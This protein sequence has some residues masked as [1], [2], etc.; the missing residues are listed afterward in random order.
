MYNLLLQSIEKKVPITQAAKIEVQ[1]AFTLKK[2]RKRDYLL[3]DGDICNEMYFVKNGCMILYTLDDGGNEHVTQF[4]VEGWWVGDMYSYLSGLPSNMFLEALEPAEVLCIKRED[5]EML[6]TTVPILERY[7]RILLE[8]NFVAIHRRV[9]NL[10]SKGAE[11]KYLD[12][13]KLYPQFALRVPQKYIASYLGITPETLS[14]IRVQS[15]ER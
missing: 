10:I 5:R 12:F 2:L 7:F 3:R 13:V 15:A 6:L 8:N 4:A 14:R 1:N 9:A 11:D